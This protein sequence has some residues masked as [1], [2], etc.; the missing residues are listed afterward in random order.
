M[1]KVKLITLAL[2]SSMAFST[3]IAVQAHADHSEAVIKERKKGF[4]VMGKSMRAMGKM[5]KSGDVDMAVVA[6][7]VK[8]IKIQSLKM[9]DWFDKEI[10]NKTH[11]TDALPVI[12]QDKA[13]F[14]EKIKALQLAAS[15][16]E[17]AMKKG[18]FEL[19]SAMLA[20][21]KS[22]G[23]CHDKYKAD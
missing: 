12:W 22:C 10:S 2:C 6:S 4:K 15:N 5:L 19:K 20:F 23:S 14:A 17:A 7:K 11:D 1:N 9:E 21:K 13:D 3:S 18:N 16:A 8:A